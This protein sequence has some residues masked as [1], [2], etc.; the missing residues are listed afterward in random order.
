[1]RALALRVLPLA[2]QPDAYVLTMRAMALLR[3]MPEVPFTL[4]KGTEVLNN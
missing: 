2:E 4:R 3:Q 1:M